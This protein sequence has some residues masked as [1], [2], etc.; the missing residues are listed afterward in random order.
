M[1][2]DNAK[3]YNNAM[4]SDDIFEVLMFFFWRRKRRRG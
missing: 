4:A 1:A 3:A 2:S